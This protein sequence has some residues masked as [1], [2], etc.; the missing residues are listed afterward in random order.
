[1]VVK[2]NIKIVFIELVMITS[3]LIKMHYE[4]KDF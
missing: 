2:I 1:M 3:F 4:I